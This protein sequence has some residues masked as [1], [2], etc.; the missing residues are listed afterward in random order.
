MNQIMDDRK[1]VPGAVNQDM[2][3]AQTVT[4]PPESFEP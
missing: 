2:W 3:T 4:T 1:I